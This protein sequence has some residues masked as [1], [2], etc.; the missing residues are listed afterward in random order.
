MATNST[1]KPFERCWGPPA[2][3]GCSARAVIA[4]Y[5]FCSAC[6]ALWDAREAA[7]AARVAAIRDRAKR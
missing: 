3:T 5:P 6:Q 2:G 1:L 7:E 4:T